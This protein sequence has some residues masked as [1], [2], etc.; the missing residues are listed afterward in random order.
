VVVG[1]VPDCDLVL[2]D[3]GVGDRSL[4][5]FEQD[6]QLGAKV[7]APGVRCG[8]QALEAGK[9]HLFDTVRLELQVGAAM[10]KVELLRRSRQLVSNGASGQALPFAR[11]TPPRR[12][13][14]TAVGLLAAGALVLIG[15]AVNASSSRA[16][17]RPAATLDSVIAAFNSRGAE[18]ALVADGQAQPVLRGFIADARMRDE[19]ERSVSSSGLRA[20]LQVRDVQQI[21]DSLTR[22]ARLTGHN[23]E[24]HHRGLGRFECDAGVVES[25]ALAK[26]QSLAE[27][28]PG[29]NS[30]DV[31]AQLADLA[32][33]PTFSEPEPIA[34]KGELVPKPM[35][36]LPV[37][38]HVAVGQTNS[39]A[40]DANGRRLRVGDS[41]HGARMVRVRL[42]SVD[43]VLDGQPYSV[44]VTPML[45]ASAGTDVN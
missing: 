37:I 36:R 24:A 44:P 20:T 30:F 7:L 9:V 2:M 45:S 40:F 43:F 16:A 39:F 15:S 42:E 21:A 18:I 11:P 12:T 34:A 10:L 23:C 6:G 3:V 4:C 19:L 41:V 14:V 13:T 25:A 5:L 8:G 17:Q 32:A 35:S 28:V 27:Q 33:A 29:V 38:R 31:H 26:L 1:Q 22:L